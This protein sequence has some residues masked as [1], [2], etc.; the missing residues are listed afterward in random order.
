[1]VL[2]APE[3][4]D[5]YGRIEVDLDMPAVRTARDALA[6]GSARLASLA[7]AKWLV[8]AEV[9]TS[10]RVPELGDTVRLD[11]PFVPA[12]LAV[13][14]ARAV[15]RDE[16]V[17]TLSM[18]LYAGSLPMVTLISR[19]QQFD[20]SGDALFIEYQDGWA[21]FTITDDD[22]NPLA[23]AS[24]TLDGTL[25]RTTDQTG[26]VQFKTH[27]GTHTLTVVAHGYAPFEMDVTV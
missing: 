5:R 12:G 11:H 24:V 9:A 1:M 26:R 17:A 15:M 21:T 22:G 6:L 23:G 25:T 7:R 14:R 4:I 20:I 13:V 27:R 19:S 18:I 16:M 10:R 2:H 3:S 8:S